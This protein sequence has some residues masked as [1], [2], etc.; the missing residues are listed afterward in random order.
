MRVVSENSEEDL[1]RQDAE[2]TFG[3][4]LRDL[5]ANLFRITRGA[6]K[7]YEV[8][9]QLRNLNE[10]TQEFVEAFG[11]GPPSDLF[12]DALQI[13]DD[14]T[15]Y[16]EDNFRFARI[17]QITVDGALQYAASQL[18]RQPT[19]ASRGEQEM[20]DGMRGYV[21]YIN[22]NRRAV[23]VSRTDSRTVVTPKPSRKKQK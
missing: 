16:S 10:A 1:A 8:F 18:L 4:A 5:T 23:A 9:Q 15:D 3:Y 14:L 20:F 17:K 22:E 7:G 19:H 13:H 2:R 21:D 11:H 12:N 6:G